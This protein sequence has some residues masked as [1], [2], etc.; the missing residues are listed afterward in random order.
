MNKLVFRGLITAFLLLVLLCVPSIA[1][2]DG[3]T[4]TLSGV[5]F[6]DGGTASGSF[7]YDAL[8]NMYSSIDITTTSG[9]AFAGTTYHALSGVFGTSNSGMLLGASGDLT[10]TALLFLLFDTGLTDSGGTVVLSGVG[11]GTCDNTDCSLSTLD[12]SLT[13]GEVVGTVATPE[14]SVLSLLTMALIALMV[15][16]ALRKS[17]YA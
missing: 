10:N 16:A 3:I 1:S 12:R 17:S 4:W 5:T 7:V 13:G 15:V 6:A 14:P 8:T 2:A 11:E 9:P